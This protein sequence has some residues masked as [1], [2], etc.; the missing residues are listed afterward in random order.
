[1][2]R[3]RFAKPE[4]FDDPVLAR[5]SHGARLLFVAT[6][7]LADR[8]GVFEWEPARLRKY[9]FGYEDISSANVSAMLAEL[10]SG[11]FLR[12]ADV[13]GRRYGLVVNLAKHQKFHVA[14]QARFEEVSKLADWKCEHPAST[15]LAP[16]QN[17]FP[18]IP[19][20]ETE[21]DTENGSPCGAAEI[22]HAEFDSRAE[23]SL[24]APA[25]PVSKSKRKRDSVSPEKQAKAKA[26][27]ALYCTEYLAK[28]GKNPPWGPREWGQLYDLLGSWVPEDLLRLVPLFFVWRNQRAIQSGHQWGKGPDCFVLKAGELDA[29]VQAPERR[30]TA[31]IAHDR[32][33]Q[34]DH[35]A[36]TEDQA[37][38]VAAMMISKNAN[39]EDSRA[40][41]EADHAARSLLAP[42]QRP[43]AGAVDGETRA[44]HRPGTRPSAGRGDHAANDAHAWGPDPDDPGSDSE[45]EPA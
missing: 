13:G 4:F 1:M 25:A 34:D 40:V 10:L 31:A 39:R 36:T 26:I 42:N 18:L 43:S 12:W 2:A 44:I 21:T 22:A 9:A 38:R 20:L 45:I 23:L 29:D 8:L 3:S 11:G 7:Q 14:E 6:W 35:N 17:P 5:C 32:Q 41:R 27:K 15:L 19:S 30:K 37:A 16:C 24:T 28:Y 33:K